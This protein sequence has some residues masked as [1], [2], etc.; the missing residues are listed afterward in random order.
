MDNWEWGWNAV[1][2]IGQVVGAIATAGAVIVALK[3]NKTKVRVYTKRM[4]PYRADPITYKPVEHIGSIKVTAT[5]KSL[6]PVE[7][8]AM[9][10][11]NPGA[12]IT[13]V[14]NERK[15]LPKLLQ[16]GESIS[17]NFDSQDIKN[18]RIERLK[19]FYAC[20]STGR[21]HYQEANILRIVLRF[22][23]WNIGKY[24]KKY[25]D[26]YKVKEPK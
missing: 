1:A 25:R 8:I 11:R 15:K 12:C 22:F 5:N 16:P 23:W 6:F 9:G 4:G 19:T 13:S 20:D 26:P 7:I 18:K 14:E 10:Y 21:T 2:A 24:L 17:L 3:Q